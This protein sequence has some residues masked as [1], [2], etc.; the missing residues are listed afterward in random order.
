MKFFLFVSLLILSFG[1]LSFASLPDLVV[2]ENLKEFISEDIAKVKE[3][4]VKNIWFNLNSA[5]KIFVC[6]NILLGAVSGAEI[7]QTRLSEFVMSGFAPESLKKRYDAMETMK[8]GWIALSESEVEME[9]IVTMTEKI[10]GTKQEDGTFPS[11]PETVLL[12][13][14]SRILKVRPEALQNE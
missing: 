5:Q 7:A 13:S 9:R 10:L 8:A 12:V 14:L 6:T 3:Q 11:L 4:D 1:S 2:H